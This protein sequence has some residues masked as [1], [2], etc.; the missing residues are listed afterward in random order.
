MLPPPRT[1]LEEKK[2]REYYKLKIKE[3]WSIVDMHNTGVQSKKYFLGKLIP[4]KGNFIYYE[5]FK[6]VSLRSSS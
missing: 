3:A 1:K 2:Q 5:I 6:S 4:F